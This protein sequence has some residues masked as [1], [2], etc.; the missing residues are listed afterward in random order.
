[1]FTEARDPIQS[2]HLRHE[3]F[4]TRALTGTRL[5][6]SFIIVFHPSEQRISAGPLVYHHLW[7]L[8]SLHEVFEILNA[9]GRILKQV[10]KK[11]E[12]GDNELQTH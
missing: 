3:A 7:K 5:I 11:R 6:Q 8:G 4:P 9:F 12:T 10:I 2:C 1:M